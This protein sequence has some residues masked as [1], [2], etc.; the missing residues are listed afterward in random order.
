LIMLFR[1]FYHD[2]IS[3]D[4]SGFPANIK[5]RIKKAIEE[6]ILV[7]PVKYGMPLKRELHGYR[8]LRVGDYRVI[9]KIDGERIK[10]LKIGIRRDVYEGL[11]SRL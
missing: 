9:Y 11:S 2:E 10:I 8:K 6:R 1:P 3:K 7:D 5:E 4:I